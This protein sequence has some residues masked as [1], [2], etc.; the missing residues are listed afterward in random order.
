MSQTAAVQQMPQ[1][2]KAGQ[3]LIAG[4]LKSRRRFST[5]EGPR[6][7]NL[8]TMP[9]PDAYSSPSTVSI[10][11]KAPVGEPETDVRVMCQVGGRSRSYK[12][13][14]QYTGEQV[15]VFTADNR[16]IAIE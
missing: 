16:L 6:F 1:S 9:A 4:R 11:S 15:T 3:V 12:A 2:I 8:V 10:V 5:Q 13:A 14:D 7:E